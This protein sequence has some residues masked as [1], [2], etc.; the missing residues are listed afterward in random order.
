MSI[1]LGGESGIFQSN[2]NDPSA[3][4]TVS[5]VVVYVAL[6]LLTKGEKRNITGKC[7]EIF[8]DVYFRCTCAIVIYCVKCTYANIYTLV[9]QTGDK[10]TDFM[11]IFKT[12]KEMTRM[13]SFQS[14]DWQSVTFL[15]IMV[16]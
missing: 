1:C 9:R 8:A 6:L 4:N 14:L 3:V 7:A 16:T 2:I 11:N 12:L 5:I 15:F 10:V 13:D